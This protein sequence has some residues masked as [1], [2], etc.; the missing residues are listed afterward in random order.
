[1]AV[2]Q[3][4]GV[5]TDRAGFAAV[6]SVLTRGI[7]VILPAPIG[8]TGGTLGIDVYRTRY[9]IRSGLSSMAADVD[10]GVRAIRI[11]GSHSRFSI[12]CLQDAD[13]HLAVLMNMV[14][15]ADIAIGA[16]IRQ[17]CVDG[18]GSGRI[19]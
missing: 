18:V 7:A 9:P 1:M 16:D 8:M 14:A 13:F 10:A 15:V 12:E 11:V 2:S 19:R 4:R 3:G 6:F 5:V 17:G